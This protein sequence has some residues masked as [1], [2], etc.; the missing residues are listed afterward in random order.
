MSKICAGDSSE[1]GAIFQTQFNLKL[2]RT[3]QLNITMSTEVLVDGM[4]IAEMQAT[5]EQAERK[6]R[7]ACDQIVLLNERLSS[8]QIRYKKARDNNRKSLRYPLRLRLAM[9]EGIRNMYYDYATQKVEEIERLRNVLLNITMTT[10]VLPDNMTIAEMQAVLEKAE[11][12]FRRA[13]DQIVL[14]NERLSSSQIRYKKA[15][16]NNRKSLRY[17]LRLRLAMIEGI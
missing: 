2:K 16:S 6:F 9:I 5:L 17:P 10:E 1:G 7:R 15:R 8:C 13:C 4:T 3:T 12:K 11:R 14:L